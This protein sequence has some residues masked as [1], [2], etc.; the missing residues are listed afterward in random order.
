MKRL[1]LAL[2]T[3]VA[4]ATPVM[5]DCFDVIGCTNSDRFRKADLREMSCQLLWDIRNRIYKDNGYCFST[6]KAIEYFGNE[7]CYISKQSAVRLNK[8]ERYNVGVI[9]AVEREKGC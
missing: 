2:L 1:V 9:K 7:G 5:A 3:A 6:A 8:T 4:F